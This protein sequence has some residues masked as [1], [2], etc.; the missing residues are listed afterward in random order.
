MNKAALLDRDGVIN[1]K[2][3]RD[4]YITR[5]EEMEFLPGVS[6]AIAR[7]NRAGYR[8]LV[9]TNQRCIAKQLITLA[10][11]HTLHERMLAAFG[12]SG[13]SIHGVY[14]CP[15][16]VLPGCDCRKPR[17]GLIL[18]AARE[19]N[20]DPTASWMIGDSDTD[21]EA[22][23][24]AGCKTARILNNGAI[25]NHK[26]DL[27]SASLLEVTQQILQL[28]EPNGARPLRSLSVGR[29]TTAF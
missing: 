19:H 5:W 4:G 27:I 13:A 11:L 15:H 20:L 12:N 29:T 21:I 23:R 17:P 10:E 26:A 6:E 22:G 2:A 16:D 1:R 28:E 25:L 7:F 3:P 9:V 24:N 14:C 8:V 18:Q